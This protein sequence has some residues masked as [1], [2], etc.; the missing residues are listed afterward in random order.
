MVTYWLGHILRLGGQYSPPLVYI[1]GICFFFLSS[2]FIFEKFVLISWSWAVTSLFSYYPFCSSFMLCFFSTQW[3]PVS[4]YF[5][6]REKFDG[7]YILCGQV[8]LN[9]LVSF[10][11]IF[12]LETLGFPFSYVLILWT[13]ACTFLLQG[14][15][16][17]C[18]FFGICHFRFF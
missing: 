8:S 7:F 15:C 18:Y 16:Q 14:F 9:F 13:F 4:H 2:D 5:Y 1:A 11:N 10:L 3:P 12:F 6:H 17:L